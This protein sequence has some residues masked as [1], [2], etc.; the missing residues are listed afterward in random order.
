MDRAVDARIAGRSPT[1]TPA[2]NDTTTVKPSATGSS[3][4][5]STRGS[6][7]RSAAM[8]ARR[9]PAPTAIPSEPA[10]SREQHAFGEQL[11]DDSTARGTERPSHRELAVSRRCARERQVREVDAR[12]EQQEP[13]GTHQ[14]E[15]SRTHGGH[16]RLL[17]RRRAQM[18]I[19]VV[20]RVIGSQSCRDR[21][22]LGRESLDRRTGSEPRDDLEIVLI[23]IGGILRRPLFGHP[24][25]GLRGSEPEAGRHD[26][27]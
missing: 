20:L 1:A 3:V 17:Q 18:Q 10:R 5:S 4:T 15:Q 12:D 25:V 21:L 23:A 11:P 2:S 7:V 26:A 8:M 24:Q 9:R 16:D 27:R 19:R 14:H 13:D 22:Q 6:D